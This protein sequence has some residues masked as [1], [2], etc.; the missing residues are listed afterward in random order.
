MH[1]AQCTLVHTALT[2]KSGDCTHTQSLCVMMNH[3]VS[4]H[5][6]RRQTP[7]TQQHTV[8]TKLQPRGGGNALCLTQQTTLRQNEKEREDAMS[9]A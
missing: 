9:A 7:R 5:T 6:V 4:T 2:P 3:T 8:A 1:S